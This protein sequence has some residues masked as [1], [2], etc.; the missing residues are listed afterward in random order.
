MKNPASPT[1]PRE[2]FAA[3]FATGFAA[4]FDGAF[5][6]TAIPPLS[7]GDD[8][9]PP[10]NM[11]NNPAPPPPLD[12]VGVFVFTGAFAPGALLASEIFGADFDDDRNGALNIGRAGAGA[13]EGR[14]GCLEGAAFFAPVPPAAPNRPPN[15]LEDGDEED[16]FSVSVV[17]AGLGAAASGFLAAALPAPAPKRPP[18]RLEGALAVVLAGAAAAF[19]KTGAA[20]EVARAG[21]V[22]DEVDE[23]FVVG[24]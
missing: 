15:G 9:R 22:A 3:G 14:G 7:C 24:S 11:P 8:P 12:A 4:G 5:A 16:V 19:F 10:P 2:G 23:D 13:T 17:V 18:N 6:L 1:A 21:P 20:V